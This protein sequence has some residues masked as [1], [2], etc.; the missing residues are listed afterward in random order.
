MIT[1]KK[2]RYN[3][4]LHVNVTEKQKSYLDEVAKNLNVRMSE[5]FR[6]LI[7]EAIKDN[8]YLKKEE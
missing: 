4:Q 7:N 5:V 1:G 3:V 8:K 6:D 2:E